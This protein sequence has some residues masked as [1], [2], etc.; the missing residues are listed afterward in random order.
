VAAGLTEREHAGGRAV[1]WIS[2]SDE[3][4]PEN[5]DQS[6]QMRWIRS[7]SCARPEAG[8]LAHSS[9]R[10]PRTDIRCRFGAKTV[11]HDYQVAEH[12][13]RPKT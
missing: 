9:A 10:G 3:Q 5:F 1:S 2:W 6:D 11:A 4:A 8:R 12:A 13:A 7:G